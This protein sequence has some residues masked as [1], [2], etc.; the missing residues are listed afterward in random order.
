MSFGI[1]NEKISNDD[2]FVYVCGEYLNFS[3]EE[4]EE[5]FSKVFIKVKRPVYGMKLLKVM[6]EFHLDGIT[7]VEFVQKLSS[8]VYRDYYYV[9]LDKNSRVYIEDSDGNLSAFLV[10]SKRKVQVDKF[11]DLIL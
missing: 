2:L 5:R 1:E 7:I 4:L 9:N 6:K 11:I 3:L 10:S 8:P